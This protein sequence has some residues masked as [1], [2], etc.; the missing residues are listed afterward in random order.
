MVETKS[1]NAA[2]FGFGVAAGVLGYRVSKN[3]R[4]NDSNALSDV[5]TY[6]DSIYNQ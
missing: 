4:S 6:Y 3:N 5:S 1:N 2:L